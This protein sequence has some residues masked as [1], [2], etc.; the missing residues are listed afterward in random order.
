MADDD[1][2]EVNTQKVTQQDLEDL[3]TGPEVDASTLYCSFMYS[4]MVTFT[5]SGGLPILYITALLNYVSFYWSYKFL[6]THYYQK[7]LQF[8]ELLPQ[9]V[10]PFFKT[11]IV[12]HVLVTFFIMSNKDITDP[13]GGPQTSSS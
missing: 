3:Y 5:F 13:N 1:D 9:F 8:N 12:I 7:T 2:K 11:A 10:I 4:T 6:F